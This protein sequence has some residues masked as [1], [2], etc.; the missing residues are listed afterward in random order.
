MPPAT[1]NLNVLLSE[2]FGPYEDG[3]I[4]SQEYPL[5]G[6]PLDLHSFLLEIENQSTGFDETE[7]LLTPPPNSRVH[8]HPVYMFGVLK[9]K[10]LGW[11]TECGQLWLERNLRERD[12]KINGVA[13]SRLTL[14]G[15]YGN[16]PGEGS[17]ISV[18]LKCE[19]LFAANYMTATVDEGPTNLQVTSKTKVNSGHNRVYNVKSMEISCESLSRKFL[20]RYRLVALISYITSQ[21]STTSVE[22]RTPDWLIQKYLSTIVGTDLKHRIIHLDP[23]DDSDVDED[24]QT[25]RPRHIRHVSR[26]EVYS[27]FAEHAEWILAQQLAPHGARHHKINLIAWINF[28][29]TVRDARKRGNL[30]LPLPWGGGPQNYSSFEEKL[31]EFGANEEI[32]RNKIENARNSKSKPSTS[33]STPTSRLSEELDFLPV[34]PPPPRPQISFQYDP[35]FSEESTPG[36]TD[37]SES[38]TES[39]RRLAAQ[40]P[41]FCWHPPNLPIG[42]LTWY[43]PGSFPSAHPPSIPVDP[44]PASSDPTSAST[45]TSTQTSPPRQKPIRPTPYRCSYS[46]NFLKISEENLQYVTPDQAEM[47]QKR[48][49]NSVNDKDVQDAFVRMVSEHYKVHIQEAGV[50]IVQLGPQKF[51]FRPYTKSQP[52]HG[53]AGSNGTPNESDGDEDNGNSHTPLR[54]STR[55]R[56]HRNLNVRNLVRNGSVRVKS[57]DV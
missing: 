52:L 51:R 19:K 20:M 16:R 11:L 38:E 2:P 5:R 56:V 23:K 54:R 13:Q 7:F 55:P 18:W 50:Q 8:Q 22:D 29:E 24:G 31:A 44:S 41:R 45:S 27:V 12:Q 42:C 26:A 10:S 36:E 53:Q 6:N 1:L 40:I 57:E 32:W 35:D 43:C 14:R 17:H 28:C 30:N 25:R 15:I 47:L 9:I 48:R 4:L 21:S 33:K 3:L 34:V 39:S 49:W 37:S 46:I